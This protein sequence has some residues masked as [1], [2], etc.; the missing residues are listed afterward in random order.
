MTVDGGVTARLRNRAVGALVVAACTSGSGFLV[1]IAVA[2]VSTVDET[3]RFAIAAATIVLL[4]ALARSAVTDPLVVH[5]SGSPELRLLGRASVLG[6]GG[7]VVAGVAAVLLRSEYLVV[8]AL[9]LHGITLRE[10]A[11]AVLVARGSTRAAASVEAVWLLAAAVS[12]GATTLGPWTAVTAF[13]V[14]AGTG[15]ALGYASCVWQRFD[16]V[17]RW[18]A[19][20]VPTSRSVAFAADTL[21]GSGV[22]QLVTW[23]AT[24]I[25]G[26]SV[27][28][29]LRGAGTLAGPVTV[30]LGA[31]RSLLIPRAVS[32]LADGRGVR[33]LA[34]DTAV[35][36]L[37]AA[38]ALVVLAAAG[39]LPPSVGRALLG[40]TWPLVA[41]VLL[42]TAVELLFQLVASVPESAH[43]ALGL[44]RRIVALRTVSAVVRVPAAVAAAPFGI[45][46]LVATST[47]VTAVNAVAWWCS[48]LVVRHGSSPVRQPI[49]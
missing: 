30:G 19:T 40:D 44:S 15:S 33:G 32:R 12:F 9:A 10:C 2:R 1:A 16:V 47:V 28:A 3:G 21:I 48:L 42:C 37:V 36:C 31:V 4:T 35:L 23:V 26:L 46:A 45:G 24:A 6:L 13:A 29:A 11:R 18:R 17:P 34:G 20:P 14:W 39:S 7:A 38:P 43:R 25:G 5:P 22:V 49:R 41:P 8:G 27:A